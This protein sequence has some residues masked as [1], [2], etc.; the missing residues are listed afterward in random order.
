MGEGS[1]LEGVLAGIERGYFQGEIAESAFREQQRFER[2]SLVKVGVN[3]YADEASPAIDVLVIPKETEDRQIEAVRALRATRDAPAAAGALDAL[4]A[5]AG[6]D[7]NL[8]E[9]LVDC[10]RAACTE[11][12]IV[13]ALRTVF[14]EYQETP[15]F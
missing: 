2:G 11:G 13:N 14:G 15:R 9:P 8:I 3:R 10:A 1:M 7:A 4:V 12:E 6:T 5:A